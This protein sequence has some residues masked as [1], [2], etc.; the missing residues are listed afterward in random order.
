MKHYLFPIELHFVHAIGLLYCQYTS[1]IQYVLR[2]RPFN[3]CTIS[4]VPYGPKFLSYPNAMPDH[5]NWT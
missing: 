2:E 5:P 1:I 3:L 4:L